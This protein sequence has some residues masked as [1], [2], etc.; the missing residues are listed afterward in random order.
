MIGEIAEAVMHSGTPSPEIG[1]PSGTR[2]QMI[3]YIDKDGFELARAHRFLLPDGSIG[4]SGR[5][6][7][8]RILDGGVLYRLEKGGG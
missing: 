2:S 3:S 6:D 4:A 8:K 5:P 1:L 7:P